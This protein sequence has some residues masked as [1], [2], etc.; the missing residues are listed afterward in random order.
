[1]LSF[2]T[3]VG[4]EK[5]RRRRKEKERKSPQQVII[6][7]ARTSGIERWG[8]GQG[9]EYRNALMWPEIT[10][11]LVKITTELA[12]IVGIALEQSGRGA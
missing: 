5:A 11:T 4:C 8:W 7:G 1:M 6:A 3:I 12:E 9:R 10:Q 2:Q